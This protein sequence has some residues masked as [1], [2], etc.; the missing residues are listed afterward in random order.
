LVLAH[1]ASLG[2][3]ADYSV[4]MR[5][6][7]VAIGMIAVSTATF[8]PPLREAFDRGDLP[9]VRLGFR[10]LVLLRMSLAL[11][12]AA[13][14]VLGGN[15]LVRVWLNRTDIQFSGLVWLALA[16]LLVSTTWVTAYSDFLVIMDR[17]WAQVVLVLAN[18]SATVILT[19]WLVPQLGLL[20]AIVAISAMTVTILTW[21]MPRLTRPLFG[22][23]A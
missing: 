21:L 3:V 11:A 5:V 19:L 14:L 9:W 22:H 7:M 18:G 4:I 17:I 10:R 23:E 2:T 15:W 12:A 13:T 1:R 16:G 20:G 8:L 6:Y